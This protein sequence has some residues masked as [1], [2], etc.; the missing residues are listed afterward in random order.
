MS[1]TVNCC[2]RKNPRDE[3]GKAIF[4]H[5]YGL[6]GYSFLVCFFVFVAWLDKVHAQSSVSAQDIIQLSQTQHTIL[7]KTSN[8]EQNQIIY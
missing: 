6:E 5:G 3:R 8:V 7:H 4:Q 2:D 1:I